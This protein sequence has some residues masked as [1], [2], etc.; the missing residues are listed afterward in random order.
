MGERRELAARRREAERY[1]GRLEIDPAGLEAAGRL[2]DGSA[3]GASRE[4]P[5]VTVERSAAGAPA[6]APGE[7]ELFER[8]GLRPGFNVLAGSEDDRWR[9]VHA[10]ARV[11]LTQLGWSEVPMPL[12]QAL[13]LQGYELILLVH[14]AVTRN[15]GTRRETVHDWVISLHQGKLALATF[16]DAG[17]PGSVMVHFHPDSVEPAEAASLRLEPGV[18]VLMFA[19]LPR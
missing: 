5:G 9:T 1:G 8:L 7:R 3:G 12:E 16:A 4:L 13:M 17:P 11:Q 15:Q 18:E 2:I 14:G 10:A 6:A 19:R